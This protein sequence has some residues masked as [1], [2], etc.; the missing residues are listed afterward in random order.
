MASMRSLYSL[1]LAASEKR[2]TRWL[3]LTPNSASNG[4]MK[5]ANMSSSKP[6]HSARTMR[7]TSGFTSV[8]NTTARRPSRSQLKL[9]SRQTS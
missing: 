4:A 5:A 1:L 6:W 7:S 8:A 9:I 3:L 2:P